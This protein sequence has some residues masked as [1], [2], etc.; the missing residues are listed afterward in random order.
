MDNDDVRN[1][2]GTNRGTN[3]S[4]TGTAG[5]SGAGDA[6]AKDGSGPDMGEVR[7]RVMDDA[8]HTYENVKEETLSQARETTEHVKRAA[9]DTVESG[10][11]RLSEQVGSVA[12]AIHRGGESFREDGQDGL[13]DQVEHLADRVDSVRAF[14]DDY[15]A[16]GAYDEAR[17]LTRER[18]LLVFGGALAVGAVA[19]AMFSSG[20]G[21]RRRR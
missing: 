7:Q 21:G 5:T 10:A 3:P 20:S 2:T 12:K 4:T 8:R 18:P 1:T 17:R 13:A 6:D 19:A 9:A 16:Q 14:L 15:G 11:S